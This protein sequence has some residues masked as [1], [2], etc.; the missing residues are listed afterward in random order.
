ME[1]LRLSGTDETPQVILDQKEG[2][3]ELSGRSLPYDAAEWFKP[4]SQW[5]ETYAQNPNPSTTFAFKLEYFNTAS[6]KALI[7]LLYILAAIPGTKVEWY[8]QD[9][10]EDMEEA[11]EE[12]AELVNIPFTFIALD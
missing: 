8:F 9:E 5:L 7:D 12:F 2:I 11:G 4:V 6:S 3:F 1:A 10:D